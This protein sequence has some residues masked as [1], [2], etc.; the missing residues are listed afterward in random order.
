MITKKTLNLLGEKL[1]NGVL[2][3]FHDNIANIYI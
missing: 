1:E 2:H 3:V